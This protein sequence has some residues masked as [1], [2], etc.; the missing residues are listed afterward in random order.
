M[1][2]KDA[3]ETRFA[4][5]EDISFRLSLLK[6]ISIVAVV[7][8]HSYAQVISFKGKELDLGDYR[9]TFL[10]ENIVNEITRFAVPL[11]FCISG[12]LFFVKDY[13]GGWQVFVR[14]KTK[15]ILFPYL[16][17][18]TV[19]IGYM[20]VLQSIPFAHKYFSDEHIV[21]WGAADWIRAYVG[22]GDGW[23]PYL[24]P[25]WF[26]PTLYVVF[27]VVCPLKSFL[28]KWPI[29]ILFVMAF[30]LI[31]QYFSV[32]DVF[33]LPRFV[34]AVSFF[35]MGYLISV[36][37]KIIDGKTVC[38]IC[39][40]FFFA[41]RILR[42]VSPEYDLHVPD[43]ADLYPGVVF[44]FSLSRYFNSFPEN[45]KKNLLK[46]SSFSFL[47][48]VLHEKLLTIVKKLCYSQI[49]L[50]PFVPL[51]LFFAIPVAVIAILIVFGAVLRKLCPN[52]SRRL[53]SR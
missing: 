52:L 30:N 36:Y 6:F 44:L 22:F 45:V 43:A 13:G 12:L 34:N 29:V 21:S 16:L 48:Y 35:C 17:W 42:A 47:I 7:Y 3:G 31:C 23:M 39:G 38:M 5:S 18:N 51:T 37:W 4:L 2:M 20:I 28:M 46:L 50:K 33:L 14:K 9:F 53:F 11:F 19:C 32:F 26:L 15:S 1:H 24:Y 41:S 27:L 49:P 40:L 25:L 10:A 8:L